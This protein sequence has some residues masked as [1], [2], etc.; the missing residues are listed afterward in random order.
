MHNILKA[1]YFKNISFFEARQG[2][3]PSYRWRRITWGA[4]SLLLKGVKW[5]VG[6]GAKIKVCE[7]ACLLG[8]DSHLIPTPSV[9]SNME[10]R[11]SQLINFESG[12][13]DIEKLQVTFLG[14]KW[15]KVLDV[16]LM[17]DGVCHEFY[18]WP[19]K[20]GCYSVRSGY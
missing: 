13:W 8:R 4:K 9:N 11:V 14:T 20:D 6:N 16:P 10:L 12:S 7:D 1:R 5:R 15:R 3:D 19:N 2:F 18:W 17:N